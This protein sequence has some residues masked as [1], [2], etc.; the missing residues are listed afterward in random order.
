MAKVLEM[1]LWLANATPACIPETVLSEA[2]RFNDGSSLKY[3]P[4]PEHGNGVLN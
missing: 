4:I 1:S 3:I 2:M